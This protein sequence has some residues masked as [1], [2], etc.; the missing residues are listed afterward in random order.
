MGSGT[1]GLVSFLDPDF[2]LL[3]PYN[4]QFPFLRPRPL[5]GQES[6]PPANIHV[7]Y[8]VD[9]VA[10]DTWIWAKVL[11]AGKYVYSSE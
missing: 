11:V 7:P 2:C 5:I 10:G 6:I 1:L 8:P 4:I 3:I 9:L